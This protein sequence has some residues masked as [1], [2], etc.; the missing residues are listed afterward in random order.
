MTESR[1]GPPSDFGDLFVGGAPS[2]WK[3]SSP[4]SR[5][6]CAPRMTDVDGSFE[7][8]RLSAGQFTLEA[9]V[10]GGGEAVL[11]RV[12]IGDDVEFVVRDTGSLQGSA[13]YRSDASSPDLLVVE[14]VRTD[15]ST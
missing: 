1:V 13:H 3:R 10:R 9:R 4:S 7:I 2:E 14:L 5:G 6:R 15:A 8:R 12:A 11:S